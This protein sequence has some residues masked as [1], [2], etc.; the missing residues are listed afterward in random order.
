M[1]IMVAEYAVG[2]GIHE[3]TPE[4]RAMLRTLVRSFAS[5]GHEVFYPTAGTQL[6]EGAGIRAEDFEESITRISKQCDAGLIIAPDEI[7]GDLT[8]LVEENTVN[9]GCPA[10]SVRLC[11]DKLKCTSILS[12]EKIPVPETIESGE[13]KGDYVIKPRSGCAS[14]GIHRSVSGRLKEGFIATQFI[15]GEHLSVSII[16]GRTQLPLTVNRQ[17]IDINNTISY[18]GGTVPY[19]CAR[20]SEIV[21]IAKK[22]LEL[23][24]CRGYAGVDIVLGDR[25]YVVDVNPRPT[26]S[27]IGISRVIG[28]EIADLILKSRFGELPHKVDVNGSFTFKKD[29]LFRL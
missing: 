28:T 8:E 23:L 20:N 9:L 19:Y 5:C 16:T 21:E 4:G 3:F 17:L 11:A 10:D 15:E 13:Y 1:R 18:K 25:P 7:L 22:A 14:D 27:I 29:E 26:T 24:G 6:D 2:E 12:Q